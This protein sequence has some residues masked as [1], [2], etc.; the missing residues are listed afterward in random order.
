MRRANLGL[1]AI[2]FTISQTGVFAQ[3]STPP[4]A[5]IDITAEQVQA[6]LKHTPPSTDRQLR[7]VDMG[8][9]QL[10]VGVIYRGPTGGTNP[11]AAGPSAPFNC[12]ETSGANSGVGGIY[13][14]AT[15]ETYIITSGGGTLVTGGHILNGRRSEPDSQVTTILN[16]PSCSGLIAGA[17]VVRRVVKTGDIV[18]IPAKVPHGWTDIT[19][20]VTY[21]SVRPDP[22][23]V[24]Q[25]GYVHPAIKK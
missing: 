18:I 24:L 8:T 3:S 9:Y 5:A 23:K 14:D 25:K 21:L 15:T 17:D 22:Q 20:H 12:G 19:D 13:H 2:L 4:K 6:V 11:P 1:L 7:I 16:G 10:A